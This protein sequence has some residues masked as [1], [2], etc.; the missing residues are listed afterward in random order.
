MSAFKE[1]GVKAQ[2]VRALEDLNIQHPSEIQEKA[3]KPILAGQEIIATAPTGSGK[4]AAYL[5]PTLQLLKGTKAGNPR[6]LIVVPTKE[7]AQ[8]VERMG[9]ELCMY[10][11]IKIGALIGGVG[12]NIQRALLQQGLDVIVGTPGRFMDLYL[13]GLIP[14][15]KI[16]FLILDEADRLM[17]MGFLNQL[18]SILEVIPRKARKLLFSATFPDR[19]QNLVDDFMEFPLR[20][21]VSKQEKPVE[22][23]TQI[24]V[25]LLNRL[26]KLSYLE[27]LLK[28]EEL[29]RVIVFTRTKDAATQTYKYLTR[30]L[31][32][33]IGVLHANK[34]QHTRSNT[35]EAF[36][37]GELRVLVTTDVSARG[38]DIPLVSHVINF[39]V[40]LIREEYVHRIGRTARAGAS[41]VAMTFYT[42]SEQFQIERLENYTEQTM[43]LVEA[44]VEPREFLPGEE[45]EIR[46]KMD[47]HRQK[48]DPSYKGAFHEKKKKIF[49]PKKLGGS[50]SNR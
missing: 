30:K 21:E 47:L 42:E 14:L 26:T 36:R 7:L 29:E 43:E 40:P 13:E 50:N 17:E 5:L 45:K 34:G 18:H 32:N 22:S 35:Y 8:Q 28:K 10:S 49:A 23:I 46:R 48:V 6:V 19:L 44:K 2:F 33:N 37:N 3:I 16:E 25:P 1:L 31:G 11:D 15:K 41:G 38:V 20:I 4:T 9:H 27:E 24:K 39:D 12:K